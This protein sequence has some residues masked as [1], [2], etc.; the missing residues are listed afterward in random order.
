MGLALL[1]ATGLGVEWMSR[2]HVSLEE[3]SPPAAAATYRGTASGDE[4]RPVGE[5]IEEAERTGEPKPTGSEEAG[6]GE[7]AL[8]TGRFSVPTAESGGGGNGEKAAAHPIEVRPYYEAEARW[9]SIG[10]VEVGFGFHVDG[11]AVLMLFT[12]CFISF[13]VHL[14]STE[15][16]RDDR[17][18]THYF[19]SLGLFTA[20]MLLMVS[21]STSLQLLLGW[22]I[23][24][25]CSF[26]LI[27]HRCGW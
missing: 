5:V 3:H 23:M 11:F 22:E 9:F 26:L 6:E 13:L 1:L 20:G 25:L 21:A 12:V 14:F 18:K 10:P 8:P 16:L 24:G 7:H 19:A 17:R 15:Y 2:G 4:A 27:G